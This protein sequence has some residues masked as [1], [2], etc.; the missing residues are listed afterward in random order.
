MYNNGLGDSNTRRSIDGRDK[1]IADLH[2]QLAA[3]TA[4]RDETGIANNGLCK[5]ID[6]MKAEIQGLLEYIACI[7]VFATT[8]MGESGAIINLRKIEDIATKALA[9]TPAAEN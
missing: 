9:H 2:K 5:V 8:P 4:G 3:M 6:S 1:E 7:G